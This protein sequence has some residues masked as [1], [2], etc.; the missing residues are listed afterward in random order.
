MIL[1]IIPPQTKQK[2]K[3]VTQKHQKDWYPTIKRILEEPK[4]ESDTEAEEKEPT[5][6]TAD[7]LSSLNTIDIC[8]IGAALLARLAR[9]HR[10]EI[11]AVTMADIE[12]ALALKKHTDPATK[13]PAC[14][15]EDL[16]VFSQK[17]ANKLAEHRPY[18]HRIILEEGKQLRFRPLYGMSQNELL[19]LWKY[20]K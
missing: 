14:Y 5:Q 16:V 1:S 9:K 12:K 18:D 7:D 2:L 17:E 15:H 13:V 19:V 3:H 4:P 6:E 11:F 10:H 8:I 20:L